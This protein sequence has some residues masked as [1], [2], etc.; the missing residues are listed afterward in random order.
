MD[1]LLD[2]GGA[3]VASCHSSCRCPPYLPRRDWQASS[4]PVTAGWR[5]GWR[6]AACG[7]Q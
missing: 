2:S 3:H 5:A 4:D 1:S 7:T 6:G